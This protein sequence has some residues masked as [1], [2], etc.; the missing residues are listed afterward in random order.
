[1]RDLCQLCARNEPAWL[2]LDEKQHRWLTADV[3]SD[4]VVVSKESGGFLACR[5][6]RSQ[7][8]RYNKERPR[9]LKWIRW[10]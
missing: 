8:E 1:M 4:E 9:K 10:S 3:D 7:V 2:C 6:C 5:A